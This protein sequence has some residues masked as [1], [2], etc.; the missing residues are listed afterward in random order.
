VAGVCRARRGG[1]LCRFCHDNS[2]CVWVVLIGRRRR[3]DSRALWLHRHACGLTTVDRRCP[4]V[5]AGHRN[6]ARPKPIKKTAISR[7][8]NV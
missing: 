4:E 8:P 7:N 5:T 2:A 6:R 1:R 3:V